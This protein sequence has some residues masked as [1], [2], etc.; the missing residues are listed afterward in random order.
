MLK[1]GLV[2]PPW[3]TSEQRIIEQAC[4]SLEIPLES[5]IPIPH[6]QEIGIPSST[7]DF[8][9]QIDL[10]AAIVS[11]GDM[12]TL[13]QIRQDSQASQTTPF[14]LVDWTEFPSSE[15]WE[16][17]P[18]D[19]PWQ[20]LSGFSSDPADGLVIPK[21]PLI[22]EDFPA[23]QRRDDLP[24]GLPE[25]NETSDDDGDTDI[26]PGLAARLGSLHIAADGRLRFYGTASNYHFLLGNQDLLPVNDHTF[27][28][29]R[30]EAVLALEH[31]KLDREVPLRLEDELI[32]LF[33][34]WHNPCHA[35]IDQ[36]TFDLARV[37][38]RSGQSTFC[39]QSLIAAICAIG[40]A[41]KGRYHQ[42]FITYPQSLADFFAAK[43]K[44]LLEIEL[45]SPCV[46]TVQTLLLLSSHEAGGA[47]D[48]RMWLYSGMAMRL[49]FDL[50][51]HVDV[52]P[53]VEQGTFTAQEG[54]ARRT[55]FWSCVV[56]NHLWSFS[57]G[58]PFRVDSEEV[59][60]KRLPRARSSTNS[61]RCID[62]LISSAM[63]SPPIEVSQNG[64]ETLYLVVEQ[65]VSFCEQLAPLVRI[66][67]GCAKISQTTL[68][69]LSMQT[70]NRLSKWQEAIPDAIK[71]SPD[72][73]ALPHVLLLHMG[74][75]NFCI[76][77]HRPWTSKASLPRGRLGPGYQH[78]RTICRQSA[79]E[80]ASLLRKYEASYTLRTM[81]V[82]IV[83]IIFSASVILIFGLIAEDM[84][85][86][87]Q[88]EN[89]KLKIAGDLS[90]CFR[91]LDELCQS[92]ECAKRTRDFL[93][94]IQKRWTQSKRD[95]Q[96][97]LKRR[98]QPQDHGKDV[99]QKKTKHQQ[100]V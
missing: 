47:R 3:Q 93:L 5:I 60:V 70:T 73:T 30:R 33:F 54:E 28:D 71:I 37:Q 91:T 95:P 42:S 49:A 57:L 74:Y 9:S 83:T 17:S 13:N 88:S 82:Y 50:G 92:I 34:K 72:K 78:A 67:Y 15:P 97:G 2:V 16:L 58:R 52:D 23:D 26:A 96:L 8:A 68:Q 31:A 86:G 11:N 27:L 1:N 90:T 64:N 77:I 62:S 32:D 75:H 10:S 14:D 69:E 22:L 89:E 25:S 53:Y 41:F 66:L 19:W 7:P 94:A 43:S 6:N 21:E 98:N 35:T 36:V 55:T 63:I 87:S 99:S 56:V 46:S 38:D 85:Q 48:A 24:S 20:I 51:L 65:W 39:S 29:I 81:N 40:A 45:D 76:L 100:K 84:P 12:S 80:I 79:S 59:T 61:E 44:V 4:A 18:S